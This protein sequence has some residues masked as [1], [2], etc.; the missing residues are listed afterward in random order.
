MQCRLCIN[1]E[2]DDEAFDFENLTDEERRKIKGKILIQTDNVNYIP[3]KCSKTSIGRYMKS[4]CPFFESNPN[5][6]KAMHDFTTSQP[7]N[8]D[9]CPICYS[10]SPLVDSDSNDT[11]N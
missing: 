7:L 9:Y 8:K 6:T 10:Y 1:L 2:I 4:I 11:S 5:N 3:I